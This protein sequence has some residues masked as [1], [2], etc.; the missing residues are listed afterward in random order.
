MTIMKDKN[1]GSS[2]VESI[3]NNMR[4]ED[5]AYCLI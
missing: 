2:L 4:K 5:R 1:H 3:K